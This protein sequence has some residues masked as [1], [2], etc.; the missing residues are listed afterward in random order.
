MTLFGKKAN[1]A[2]ELD[3]K[4]ERI[5][6][7]FEN[8]YKDAAQLNLKEFESLLGTF[9]E[10]GKLSEKQKA[11]YERQLADCEARLENFTHKDQKPT[12]VP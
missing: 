5:Q 7:N 8:N 9:L 4:L 2:R 12:W 3:E 11:Y 6:M 1:A 10:E